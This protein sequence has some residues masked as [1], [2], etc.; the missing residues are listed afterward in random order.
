MPT[1]YEAQAAWNAGDKKLAAS[2]LKE[3]LGSNPSADAWYL[4][5]QMTSDK[6]EKIKRL[7]RALFLDPN[8]KKSI[9]MIYDLGGKPDKNF[10]VRDA[11]GA[12]SGSTGP[13]EP[14]PALQAVGGVLGNPLVITL[15][16]AV[17]AF[18]LVFIIANSV[19]PRFQLPQ[20]EAHLMRD[21]NL[22]LAAASNTLR[23]ADADTY[24]QR[25]QASGLDVAAIEPQPVPAGINATD[26]LQLTLRDI[27][28]SVNPVAFFVTIYVYADDVRSQT[29]RGDADALQALVQ[30][31]QTLHFNRTA[32]MLVP[33]GMSDLLSGAVVDNFLAVG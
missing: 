32:A 28:Y 20:D 17:L 12:S 26:V 24:T 1:V 27:D 15:A 3:V 22:P 14:S 16:T 18:G 6:Q 33:G 19:I 10:F 5:A 25:F 7:Q 2:I 13:R 31:G 11:L 4:A 23:Y 9:G 30:P 29:I 21:P 8:H